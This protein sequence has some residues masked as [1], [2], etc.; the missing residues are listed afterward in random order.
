[1]GPGELVDLMHKDG[2]QL[3]PGQSDLMGD[4]TDALAAWRWASAREEQDAFAAESHNKAEAAVKD[5][6]F[7]SGSGTRWRFLARK[8]QVNVFKEE[9]I[10]RSRR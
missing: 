2:F 7:D 5:G 3:P 4:L 1:M 10:F 6:R 9:E 8:G